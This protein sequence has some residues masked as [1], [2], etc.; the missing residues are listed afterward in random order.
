MRWVPALLALASSA[1]TSP[2]VTVLHQDPSNPIR[3][4]TAFAVLPLEVPRTEGGV[5]L[6]FE[7]HEGDA[8]DTFATH[9]EARARARSIFVHRSHDQADLVIRPR[10]ETL[11]AGSA[12]L[13]HA[14]ASRVVL[15][16]DI[17]W[18]DGSSIDVLRLE[19]S[20]RPEPGERP[21][22]LLDRDLSKVARALAQYL[23]DRASTGPDPQGPR[24]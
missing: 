18:R 2:A 9:L 3:G 20:T 23:G 13:L 24:S 1:C 19:S 16:V 8:G 22:D 10:F 15:R 14:R 7:I 5:D 21:E 11:Q 4:A 6:G 17:E 12:T